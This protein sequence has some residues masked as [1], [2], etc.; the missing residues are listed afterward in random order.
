LAVIARCVRQQQYNQEVQQ[1]QQLAYMDATYQQLNQ[2]VQSESA[3]T[4][5]LNNSASSGERVAVLGL[6]EIFLRRH[7]SNS[8][9]GTVLSA[10]G[11]PL[12]SRW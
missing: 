10:H 9:L 2:S 7:L 12:R 1:N 5:R 6:V 3:Q 11:D 4:K 8:E